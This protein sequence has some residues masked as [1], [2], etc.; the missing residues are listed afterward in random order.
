MTT[1]KESINR[2]HKFKKMDGLNCT[3][4]QASQ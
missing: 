4:L 2:V 1:V 3:C